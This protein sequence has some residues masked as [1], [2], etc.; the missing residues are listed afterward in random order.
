[1]RVTMNTM[2]ERIKNDLFRLTEKLDKYNAQISSGKIYQT[3]SDA[4]VKL[5]HALGIRNT[6]SDLDQYKRNIT[7]AKGW[8][9]VTENV[10]ISIEDRLQRA[11]E[12]ALQGANDTQNGDTRRAIATEVKTI[13]EEVVSLGNTKFGKR[14][15]FAGTKTQGFKEDEMPFQMDNSGNVTYHGNTEDIEL[16]ISPGNKQKINL[17]GKTSIMDSNTFKALKDLYDSLM[18]NSQPNIENAIEKL[19]KSLIYV[20]NQVA[21]LG[22]MANSIDVKEELNETSHIANKEILSN[23][24]DADMIEAITTLNATQTA[25]QAALGAA[26]KVMKVTLA[27]YL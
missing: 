6:I 17:D 13:L 21:Q 18:A 27:D 16:N 1:M 15:V 25:Y 3:P 14:F 19:D 7:Y 23:I 20:S 12:L 22:A 5:T 26:S 10:M 2:Y 4:P 9:S 24:E 11:K 8:L